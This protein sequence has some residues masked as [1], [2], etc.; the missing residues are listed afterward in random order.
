L[1]TGIQNRYGYIRRASRREPP[2]QQPLSSYATNHKLSGIKVFCFGE[3]GE[4]AR[5][6]VCA[7][8]F[9]GASQARSSSSSSQAQRRPVPLP[10]SQPPRQRV[11]EWNFALLAHLKLKNLIFGRKAAGAPHRDRA[12]RFCSVVGVRMAGILFQRPPWFYG[13][14]RVDC[15]EKPLDIYVWRAAFR[16]TYRSFE[17]GPRRKSTL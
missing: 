5:A 9:Y 17:N 6:R 11:A 3:N 15:L 7:L 12:A 2:E 16:T 14:L 8:R 10:A 13:A 1:A 4:R